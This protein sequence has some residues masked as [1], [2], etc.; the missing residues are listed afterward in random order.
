MS[1]YLYRMQVKG[2][3][4]S[5]INQFSTL[6]CHHIFE[7][8]SDFMP[9]HKCPFWHGRTELSGACLGWLAPDL[10]FLPSASLA[11]TLFDGEREL[12][13]SRRPAVVVQSWIYAAGTMLL[14]VPP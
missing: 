11:Q 12:L 13:L 6:T 7:C 5:N 14:A 1:N 2:S 10:A 8:G 3:A 9:L 4:L